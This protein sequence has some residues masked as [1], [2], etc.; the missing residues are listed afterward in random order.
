MLDIA[1]PLMPEIALTLTDVVDGLLRNSTRSSA[2]IRRL[3]EMGR[4]AEEA[5]PTVLN[6]IASE[7]G[8]THADK[9]RCRVRIYSA[10]GIGQRG[11]RPRETIRSSPHFYGRRRFDHVAIAGEEGPGIIRSTMAMQV[12]AFIGMGYANE[13]DFIHLAFGHLSDI[14]RPREDNDHPWVGDEYFASASLKE[15]TFRKRFS[16]IPLEAVNGKIVIVPRFKQGHNQ[17]VIFKDPGA[18]EFL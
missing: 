11:A 9:E 6:D 1:I 12:F 18:I 2:F 13:K 5:L 16:A 4:N 17:G 7:Y 8:I 10:I 14:Q 3:N 15:T